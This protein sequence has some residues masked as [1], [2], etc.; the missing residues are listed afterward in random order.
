MIRISPL[1][2]R[3]AVLAVP[4]FLG[5]TRRAASLIAS[6]ASLLYRS[7]FAFVNLHPEFFHL[8]MCGARRNLLAAS[9]SEHINQM[10]KGS[11]VNSQKQ[12]ASGIDTSQSSI[13]AIFQRQPRLPQPLFATR[14][15]LARRSQLFFYKVL[16]TLKLWLQESS[17]AA[18]ADFSVPRMIQVPGLPHP[19]F[20][21]APP[22]RFFWHP[23]YNSQA[24]AF[25]L[26]SEQKEDLPCLIPESYALTAYARAHLPK[27]G[28]LRQASDG[29]VYLELPAA[30]SSEIFP[31][32]QREGLEP[33]AADPLMPGCVH[34][35]VILPQEWQ[36]KRGCAKIT[37]KSETFSFE[38]KGF[39]GLQPKA[40]L[41]FDLV[42]F[43]KLESPELEAL[44]QRY[45]LPAKIR[46]HDFHC[47]VAF[48][49]ST[50]TRATPQKE[51]FRLSVA[52]YA[53]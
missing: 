26:I 31:L 27:R 16:E 32:L 5:G 11:C 12:T 14:S 22:P 15:P 18:E 42:F 17:K 34:I 33:A 44:R 37:E 29:Y 3:V 39:F 6:A 36:E 52:C 47:A 8:E 51:L 9:E 1:D 43:F 28:V 25:P 24:A 7:P 10:E 48:A 35:P 20:K 50:Q 41:G 38:I 23:A 4:H 53:A 30:F 21:V 46:A 49:K 40:G 13:G 45:L 19:A 2:I